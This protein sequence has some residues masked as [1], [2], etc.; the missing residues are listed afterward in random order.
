MLEILV[1]G[2][3]ATLTTG[4]VFVVRHP[5]LY[6]RYVAPAATTV[7]GLGL[8]AL[9]TWNLAVLEASQ[10]IML[11]TG[12]H[13]ATSTTIARDA[14]GISNTFAL[15]VVGV[16]LVALLWIPALRMRYVVA[17]EEEDAEPPNLWA[18]AA[19]NREQAGPESRLAA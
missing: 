2:T 12:N 9:T 17:P 8:T 18:E 3:V 1:V 5:E 19:R 11:F 14:Y 15:V 16:A 13:A 4:G 6:V 10:R 7:L